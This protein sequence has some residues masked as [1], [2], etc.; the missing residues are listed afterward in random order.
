MPMVTGPQLCHGF[1]VSLQPFLLST[2]QA[3]SPRA[4]I[5]QTLA[6][7]SPSVEASGLHLCPFPISQP[8]N[9]L[10]VAN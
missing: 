3:A 1:S 5:A 2:H 6:V 10:K 7:L 8:G 4:L 9:F